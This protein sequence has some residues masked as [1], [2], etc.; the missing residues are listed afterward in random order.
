VELVVQPSPDL[1]SEVIAAR[2]DQV[3]ELRGSRPQ[4]QQSGIAAHPIDLALAD[5]A[6][7]YAL[8]HQ[9]VEPRVGEKIMSPVVYRFVNRRLYL[10]RPIPDAEAAVAEATGRPVAEGKLDC[11]EPVG[12]LEGA[13]DDGGRRFVGVRLGRKF[14]PLGCFPVG[15]VVRE[16]VEQIL[17]DPDGFDVARQVLMD[18]RKRQ[19]REERVH[20]LPRTRSRYARTISIP[21][22]PHSFITSTG[23][24][25]PKA[26]L[27][28][29]IQ[30]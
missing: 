22:N 25:P 13:V 3:R 21:E 9:L 26:L 18:I 6:L 27:R 24:S 8:A 12:L 28:W 10:V 19:P 5:D 4:V 20:Q 14:V 17:R 7:A 29:L 15:R 23:V 1:L 2:M 30:A 11:I 16:V